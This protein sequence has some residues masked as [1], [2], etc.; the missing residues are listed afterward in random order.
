MAFS[1]ITTFSGRMKILNSFLNA[2]QSAMEGF[3][4]GDGGGTYS[5]SAAINIR[6]EWNMVG[7][8]AKFGWRVDTSTLGDADATLTT[9]ED[10]YIC[11]TNIGSPRTWTL[12]TTGANEGNLITISRND[13]GGGIVTVAS[14]AGGSALSVS[15][16]ARNGTGPASATF[17]FD[18]S[19]WNLVSYGSAT[20]FAP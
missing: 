16:R 3:I 9:A 8:N 18:G 15:L 12:S 19:E 2:I 14:N 1:T 20:A 11:N 13:N 5:N 7:S 6:G 4:D 17:I 10:Y